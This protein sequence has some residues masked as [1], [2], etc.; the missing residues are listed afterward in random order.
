MQEGPSV[1]KDPEK[2]GRIFETAVGMHLL[3]M[4]GHLYYWRER[5]KEVDY[6]YRYQGELYAIEVKSGR[7]KAADGLPA[8]QEKF[9]DVRCVIITPD[10]FTAFSENPGRFL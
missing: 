1:L 6:I 4:P 2:R 8:F 9:P 7:R 5:Q 10:N 3:Q